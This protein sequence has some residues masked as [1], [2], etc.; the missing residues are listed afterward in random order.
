MINHKVVKKHHDLEFRMDAAKMVVEGGRKASDVARDVGVT[1]QSVGFWVKR[2]LE[3]QASGGTTALS[4]D[5]L[6]LKAAHDEIRKL[7]VQV[8]FL[9]KT[10]A[11]FVELPK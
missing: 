4:P 5:A 9:K 6:K 1:A 10:M 8:E 3:L 7:K 11:Y 2:Y